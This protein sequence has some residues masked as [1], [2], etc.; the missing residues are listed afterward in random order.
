VVD[1][2]ASIRELLGSY[3]SR[4]GF[5]VL[6]AAD[7]KEASRLRAVED[8][9]LVVLDMV[10]PD[11]DGFEVLAEFKTA[12]P[13]LPVIMLTGMGCDEQLISQAQQAGADGM[14]SKTQ[15]LDEILLEVRR[16]LNSKTRR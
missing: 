4:F 6:T 15:A 12:L 11:R 3:L 13:Q 9:H 8:L 10:L 5:E 14:V 16:I 2:E 1:D 7:A